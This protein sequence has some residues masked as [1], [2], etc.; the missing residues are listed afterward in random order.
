MK[1]YVIG[2][3]AVCFLYLISL[4]YKDYITPKLRY[5]PLKQI[6]NA[7][8]N[9]SSNILLYVF[10]SARN[11]RECLDII[12]ELNEISHHKSFHVLGIVP[13]KEL[14][15]EKIVRLSTG[16]KFPFIPQSRYKRYV[17]VCTP[18]VVGVNTK[19]ELLFILPGVRDGNLYIKDFLLSLL[20]KLQ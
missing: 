16:A 9:D 5:F 14:E 4:L 11:C 18:A 8:T 15:N 20:K 3:V 7:E 2:A 12:D 6:E 1:K 19:A 17:P 13:D 10:L